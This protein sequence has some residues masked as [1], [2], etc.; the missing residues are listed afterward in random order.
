LSSFSLKFLKWDT[1]ADESTAELI[2]SQLFDH[3]IL[4]KRKDKKKSEPKMV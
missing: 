4:L 1:Q 2:L 3:L